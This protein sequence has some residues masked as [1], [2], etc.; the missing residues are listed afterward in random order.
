METQGGPGA[1]TKSIADT[2]YDTDLYNYESAKA[3]VAAGKRRSGR[4]RRA[5]DTAR[6]NLGYCTIHSPVAARS[7]TAASTSGRRSWPA[8]MPPACS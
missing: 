7:S 2:D 3:N 4:T 5:V 6:I 1:T 8:S